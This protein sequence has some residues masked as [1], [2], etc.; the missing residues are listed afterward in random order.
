MRCMEGTV[1]M[2]ERDETTDDVPP[3]VVTGA[4]DESEE[5]SVDTM[6]DSTS[7]NRRL[8]NASN[9]SDVTVTLHHTRG[10]EPGSD[11]QIVSVSSHDSRPQSPLAGIFHDVI[12]LCQRGLH[13]TAHIEA[14]R[15]ALKTDAVHNDMTIQTLQDQASQ[16]QDE[17][18]LLRDQLEEKEAE[19][20]YTRGL[21]M[22]KWASNKR[23]REEQ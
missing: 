1:D 8:S 17:V 19:L 5:D 10:S 2:M 14:E 11:L 21:L 23:V 16:R 9:A 20:D 22:A 7:R 18:L 6:G 4:A 12:D 15:V 13:E 3:I